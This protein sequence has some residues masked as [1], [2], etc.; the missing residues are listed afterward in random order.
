MN[1]RLAGWLC[2]TGGCHR[3]ARSRT[4]RRKILRPRTF[5][6][7]ASLAE[8][9]GRTFVKRWRILNEVSYEKL[10]AEYLAP[11]K[12]VSM[13]G[14]G[15]VG[16]AGR[17]PGGGVAASWRGAGVRSS[18]LSGRSP[19]SRISSPAAPAAGSQPANNRT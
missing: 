2:I 1:K 7:P 4:E 17:G 18:P 16:G 5:C 9:R 12:S 8:S 6:R 19:C 11:S 15:R 3:D 10:L 13:P 14:Q